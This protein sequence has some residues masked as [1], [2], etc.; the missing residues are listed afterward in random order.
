MTKGIVQ[1]LW[2]ELAPE[3]FE[4]TA[5]CDLHGSVLGNT[6]LARHQHGA[7]DVGKRVTFFSVC[8]NDKSSQ[9][10]NWEF[11]DVAV[12]SLSS[13]HRPSFQSFLSI[14]FLS[15]EKCSDDEF[16]AALSAVIQQRTAAFVLQ[17]YFWIA[18]GVLVNAP[19][20]VLIFVLRSDIAYEG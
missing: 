4:Y 10:D 9:E 18:L 14:F 7:G 5:D 17:G 15:A 13:C 1:V 20:V 16:N 3:I 8:L 2:R 11:V 6:A 19:W 12:V